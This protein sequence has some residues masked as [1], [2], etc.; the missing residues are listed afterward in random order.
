MSEYIM[1][2]PF[3]DYYVELL[4]NGLQQQPIKRPEIK[5]SRLKDRKPGKM[6][7]AKRNK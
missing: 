5:K 3:M 2:E 4:K 6:C 1:F 7:P